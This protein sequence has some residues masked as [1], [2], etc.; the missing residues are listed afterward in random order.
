MA[1]LAAVSARPF[2][3]IKAQTRS[4]SRRMTVTCNAEGQM[5]VCLPLAR[6]RRQAAGSLPLR[7]QRQLLLIPGQSTPALPFTLQVV[8]TG[9]GGRTGAL[10]E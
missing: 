5:Q 6:Q 8:V 9:A 4:A 1:A 3:A 7:L 2:T 10:G